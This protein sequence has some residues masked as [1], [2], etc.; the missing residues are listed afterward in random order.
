MTI[1][2]AVRSPCSPS[3]TL[4]SRSLS[5]WSEPYTAWR[6]KRGTN[7]TAKL[8][9]LLP[10]HEN[11]AAPIRLKDHIMQTVSNCHPQDAK[12]TNCTSTQLTHAAKCQRPM[13]PHQT[14]SVDAP[15]EPSSTAS[16]RPCASARLRAPLRLLPWLRRSPSALSPPGALTTMVSS[17]PKSPRS[18]ACS[19]SHSVCRKAEHGKHS[20]RRDHLTLSM[21]AMQ[22]FSRWHV[23]ARRMHLCEGRLQHLLHHA[24]H[25]PGAEGGVVATRRQEVDRIL[26][27]L[28]PDLA[29]RQAICHALDLRHRNLLSEPKASTRY[30]R[31]PVMYFTRC[32][33]F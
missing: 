5:R 9:N 11:D 31:F 13:G 27:H 29:L 32:T 18:S 26:R 3:L 28:Q 14:S 15:A 30:A 24:L 4:R 10:A 12:A 19:A 20:V 6:M 25:G 17:S 1:W 22:H 7:A 23:F 21:S 2:A 16:V 33:A 8:S